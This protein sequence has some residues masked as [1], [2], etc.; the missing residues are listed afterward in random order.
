SRRLRGGDIAP[1]RAGTPR[2]E[3]RGY[4]RRRRCRIGRTSILRCL[5]QQVLGQQILGRATIG[6]R[7]I[8]CVL[9]GNG[10]ADGA[11]AVIRGHRLVSTTGSAAVSVA[12]VDYGSGNLHSAAKAFERAAREEGLAQPIVVTSDPEEG[13]R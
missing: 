1:L 13:A 2:L 6:R 4:R 10:R 5:G 12:I 3:E 7:R 8:A 11:P 9:A